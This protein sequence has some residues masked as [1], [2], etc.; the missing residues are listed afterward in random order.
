[1]N[2]EAK[3]VSGTETRYFCD[4]EAKPLQLR[5]LKL[6]FL[7]I[8]LLI[9]SVA[10]PVFSADRYRREDFPP[11]FIFGA[12][13]S[14]Y[15]VEGAAYEDGRSSSIWDAFAHEGQFLLVILMLLQI[16]FTIESSL[17]STT[18]AD[19]PSKYTGNEHGDTGDVAI[20][21][22]HKYKEDVQIMAQTGIDAYRFSIS[23]SR[24]I[25]NGRGPVNP[26]GLQYYNN[27]VNELIAHG[28]QPHALLCNYDH[29]QALED[30]KDFTAYADVCFRE[31]GDR[32]S[33]W[34]TVNEPNVFA[35]GGYDTGMAPPKRC[36]PPFVFNCSK[37]N[38]SSEPYLAAHHMLLAHASTARLYREKYQAWS[39]LLNHYRISLYIFRSIPLTNLTADVAANQRAQDFLTGWIADPLMFGDYPSTMKR[40]VGSRL[41]EFTNH[42]SKLV[43]GSFDFIGL[44]HYN[45]LYVEDNSVSLKEKNRDFNRDMG[46]KLYYNLSAYEFEI[47]PRDL[48]QI[49]ENFKSAYGNPP[50]YIQENGQRTQRGSS[51]EDPSRV[52]YLHAYIGSVLD[53]IR[54]YFVWSLWDGLELLDGYESSYGLYYVDLDDP[55]LKRYPKLS[56]HWYSHFLKG[57]GVSLDGI[58]ELE[59]NLSGVSKDASFSRMIFM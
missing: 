30:E 37:G 56:A 8:T 3:S 15:Q 47:R 46:V 6:S 38:S 42:E 33:H 57:R 29:P 10:F 36:S 39:L 19:F 43:K 40:N 5:M 52:K 4:W 21:E 2:L 1:M 20:D 58:I 18:M 55:D 9:S 44:I 54:G 51:L 35:I 50:I 11:G 14:A 49:L 48:Q 16:Q 34:T 13:S 27:L 45:S 22:Y 59:K 31:F 25:P 17:S 53:A 28:I 24:L 23:W 41:P 26:K 32:V 12:G 7:L